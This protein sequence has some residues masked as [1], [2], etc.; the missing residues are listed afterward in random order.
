MRLAISK[1]KEGVLALAHKGQQVQTPEDIVKN[2]Y[3][4]EFFGIE[5]RKQQ[6]SLPY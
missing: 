2:T 1:D 4:L 3:T 5:E 6:Y